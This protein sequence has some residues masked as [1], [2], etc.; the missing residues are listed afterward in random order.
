MSSDDPISTYRQ[1]TSGSISGFTSVSTVDDPTLAESNAS[2]ATIAARIARLV[3]QNIPLHVRTLLQEVRDHENDFDNPHKDT[4]SNVSG[5]DIS[6][7]FKQL[8]SGTAPKQA[9]V[10]AL[11]AGLDLESPFSSVTCNRAS[12]LIIVDEQGFL[13]SISENTIKAD[14]STSTP[15]YPCWPEVNQLIDIIDIPSNT[16]F[17]TLGLAYTYTYNTGI[18]PD[19]FS[20]QITLTETGSLDQHAVTYY[21]ADLLTVGHDYSFNIFIYPGDYTYGTLYLGFNDKHMFINLADTG[22]VL[23]SDGSIGTVVTLPNGWI[24]AGLS[25]TAEETYASVILGYDPNTYTTL[26]DAEA[27]FSSGAQNYAGTVGKNI[28]SVVIPQLVDIAGLPPVIQSGNL[29]ATTLTYPGFQKALPL[30]AFMV[31]AATTCYNA[32]SDTTSYTI[33]TIPGVYTAT[34]HTTTMTHTVGGHTVPTTFTGTVLDG[35]PTVSA[36]SYD[37]TQ[38]SYCSTQDSRQDVTDF[39]NNTPTNLPKMSTMSFGPFR[40]GI[41]GFDQY[42]VSDDAAALDLL[43]GS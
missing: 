27:S 41:T 1:A 31:K 15:L 13:E 42:A 2:A 11:R 32:V 4:L 24:R 3:M 6:G 17:T 43:A 20:T 39:T 36:V 8:M 14:W 34:Q 16:D 10:V 29:A 18:V 28:C 7:L 35:V 19:I 30:T 9:P 5:G 26:T 40:G 21:K 37:L 25:L 38:V 12:E 33:A 22:D 23:F